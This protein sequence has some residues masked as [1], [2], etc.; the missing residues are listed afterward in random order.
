MDPITALPFIPENIVVHLG[1]P[2]QDAQN[3]T[4]PFPEYIKNVASSEIYPTWPENAIRANIYAIITFALNRIYTEW[5]RSRGYDFDI[6]NSTQYDQAFQYG[7]D[8]FEN[9][10]EIVDEIFNNYVRKQGSVAPYFTQFC[11]GTTVTC[12]GLSQ[13]GT[14]ELAN[15]GLTPLEILQYYYGDDIE[16]VQNAPIRSGIESYPGTPLEVGDAGNEIKTIQVQLNRISNN[17]PAIPKINPSNG[18]FGEQTAAAVRTFQGIFNLPQ[19]E[20][21]INPPGTKSNI[22][23]TAL[24]GWVNLRQKAFHWKKCFLP[25]PLFCDWV[26][27]VRAFRCCNTTW[28]LLAILTLLWTLSLLTV[29]LAPIQKK[30]CGTFSRNTVWQSMVLW[31]GTPGINF[32]KFMRELFLLCR[33]VI[34][35]KKRKFIQVII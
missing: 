35:A 9:I 10:S 28:M 16:I 26:L 34:R 14:V 15:Q 7:R 20:R 31:G 12:D 1:R 30:L 18:I 8:I 25:T 19:T 27:P 6:T 32:R 22:F 4:V 13:W 11:N 33:K 23:I 5:Y 3:V 2:N 17:Y 29:F 24:N 21:R